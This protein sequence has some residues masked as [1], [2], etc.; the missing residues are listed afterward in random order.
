MKISTC[1]F[2][3]DR[4][5]LICFQGILLFPGVNATHPGKLIRLWVHEVYRV[6]YDRLVDADDRQCFFE[7]VKVCAALF[8][9]I[10][11]TKCCQ[12]VGWA[13]RRRRGW[14][15]QRATRFPFSLAVVRGHGRKWKYYDS[16]NTDFVPGEGGVHSLIW[17]RRVYA[18]RYG[19]LG[20]QS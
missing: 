12:A 1:S 16:G 19:S 5:L 18:A 14:L 9:V 3:C 4:N 11:V 20:L 6:F 17:P 13:R 2:T 10:M 8:S 15:I 7:I